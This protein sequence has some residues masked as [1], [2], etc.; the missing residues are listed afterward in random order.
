MKNVIIIS[1]TPRVNGNSE[2]LVNE[3]AKGAK[4][5]GNNVEVINLR[6]YK[7]N[8]CIGCYTCHKTGKCIHND[9]MNELSEKLINADVIVFATPVYFYSMSGQLKVFIDRLVPSYTKIK[10]DIYLIAT[11]YDNDKVI[12]ENT[13]EAIRGCS[14]DCFEKCNEKGVIYGIGLGDVK[15]VFKHKDYLQQAYLY[16]KNC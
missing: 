12:M 10:A 14:R 15:E 2:I 9:G 4:E 6:D 1:S 3:F 11:Q 16:G 5:A 8:Y 7:L 13:F